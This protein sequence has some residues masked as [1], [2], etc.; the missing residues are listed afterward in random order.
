MVLDLMITSLK[1][2]TLK[3]TLQKV[4]RTF[5]LQNYYK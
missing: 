2:S 5:K 4:S 1:D 3:K